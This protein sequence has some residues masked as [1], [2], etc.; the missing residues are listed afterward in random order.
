MK[1]ND[2]IKNTNIIKIHLHETL[3][4][5]ICKLSSSHDAAF[6]FSEEG[7]YMGLVNPYYSLLKSS[8]PANA[9]VEHC[10]FHAPKIK[11]DFTT[12]KVAQLMNESK[13]HYLPVFDNQDQFVGIVSSRRMLSVLK[14]SPLFK[15][16]IS[17][18]LKSKKIPLI[19]VF[20][21]DFVSTALNELKKYKVSKL[22]VIN[23]DMKLKG[24]LSYYDLISF[25]IA[26]REKEQRGERRGDKISLTHKL[27][28]NFSKNF[29]LT[30]GPNDQMEEAL[31]LIL[32][33]KIGSVVI[34]DEERH[35]I[36]IITT[37]DFLAILAKNGQKEIL[38][39]VSKDLSQEN[40]QQLGGFLFNFNH[41][42]RK[43]P[44][45]TKARLIVKEE[46]QGG[47]FKVILSMF[48]KKGQPKVIKKEGKN[49]LKILQGIKKD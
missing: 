29:V 5:A 18:V 19:T 21:D 14:G 41:W 31:R 28:K 3:S 24:V 33:K 13:V 23:R 45:L 10:L 30:L 9:R 48:P 47:V 42:L 6:V 11:T 43:E 2:L 49:L 12:A 35:P 44:D 16:K 40:R 15:V 34:V 38:E 25:L 46:K 20:E 32:E 36:G 22:V 27:I 26:P 4:S 37:R 39:I 8:S 1:V 7:K 17:D